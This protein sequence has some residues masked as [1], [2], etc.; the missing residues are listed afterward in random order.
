MSYKDKLRPA[1]SAAGG[2]YQSKL[3]PV[4]DPSGKPIGPEEPGWFEPGSIS[5]LAA[6]KAGDVLQGFAQGASLGFSDELAGALLAGT[7][8]V[9][10][11]LAELTGSTPEEAAELTYRIT[12]K[13]PGSDRS[14]YQVARDLQR[15]T[16]EE[17][18]ERTPLGY[19]GG[20]IAGAVAGGAGLKAAGTGLG[21][22][23]TGAGLARLGAGLAKAGQIAGGAPQAKPFQTIPNRFAEL[24][25]YAVPTGAAAGLG[26]SKAD[27]TE[28]EVGGAAGD[29][30]LG[31]ATGVPA[32]MLG[33]GMDVGPARFFR[34][35]GMTEWP[36]IGKLLPERTVAQMFRDWGLEATLK[37]VLPNAGIVNRLRKLGYRSEDEIRDLAENIERAGFVRAGE[38]SGTALKRV[39]EAWESGGPEIGE[40]LSQAQR[41]SDESAAARELLEQ[42]ERY[43]DRGQGARAMQ[44]YYEAQQAAPP[45]GIAP[46]PSREFQEAYSEAAMQGA[47]DTQPAM[48]AKEQAWDRLQKLIGT[49]QPLTPGA[50]P[51]FPELWKTKSDLQQMVNFAELV[52]AEAKMFREGVAGYRKGVLEQVEKVLGPDSADVLRQKALEMSTAA[53]IENLLIEKV[54]REAQLKSRGILDLSAQLAEATKE[55]GWLGAAK[56][57]AAL[58]GQVSQPTRAAMYLGTSRLAGPVSKYLAPEIVRTTS[59]PM[60]VELKKNAY[61][62]LRQRLGLDAQDDEDLANQAYIAGQTTPAAQPGRQ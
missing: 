56:G 42:G 25:K 39:Q 14:A 12:G 31:A 48:V 53:D 37:A 23:A 11:P 51:T 60:S 57:A 32:A 16:Q 15:G 55:G 44:K 30:T 58:F 6:T 21:A 61:E 36:V 17:A 22:A 2:G 20:G 8:G 38:S 34:G 3:R 18:F 19:V 28:G 24:L 52:P 13:T 1:G 50:P 5:G 47:A 41:A 9:V 35:T 43:M 27:L 7:A 45:G 59:G 26:T 4:R 46:A 10:E 29:V 54:S 33:L 62:A 40:L 49:K